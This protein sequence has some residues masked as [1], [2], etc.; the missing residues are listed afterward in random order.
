[1]PW[2]EVVRHVEVD[3]RPLRELSRARAQG[4]DLRS[5]P[6]ALRHRRLG[7]DATVILA[8]RDAAGGNGEGDA[9]FCAVPEDAFR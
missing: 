5:D 4:P 9:M 2:R 1:M 7:V 3:L 8:H 6:T